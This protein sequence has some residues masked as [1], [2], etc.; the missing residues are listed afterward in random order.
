MARQIAA[1]TWTDRFEKKERLSLYRVFCQAGISPQIDSLF[2]P[3]IGFAVLRRGMQP[4][5]NIHREFS[6]S[7]LFLPSCLVVHG[8]S[9]IHT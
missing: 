7:K 6:E 5:G 8:T 1:R 9:P 2:Y 3:I 4:V